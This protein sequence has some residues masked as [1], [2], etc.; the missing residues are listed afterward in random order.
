MQKK[1]TNYHNNKCQSTGQL[2][3]IPRQRVSKP[4]HVKSTRAA[5]STRHPHQPPIQQDKYPRNNK[6]PNFV[7]CPFPGPS[8]KSNRPHGH[9]LTSPDHSWLLHQPQS[10]LSNLHNF[11]RKALW[12][13]GSKQNKTTYE[14]VT[15]IHYPDPSNQT[16]MF[17]FSFRCSSATCK[18]SEDAH[19]CT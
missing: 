14:S 15:T 10:R 6:A 18:R 3:D 7:S 16:E 11:H 9:S 8:K 19:L 1:A 5:W 13:T 12:K 4:A 17:H 2:W